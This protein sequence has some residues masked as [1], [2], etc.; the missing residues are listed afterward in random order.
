MW[1]ELFIAVASMFLD[2][3]DYGKPARF[4]LEAYL[5]ERDARNAEAAYDDDMWKYG[6]RG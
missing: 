5:N 6:W 4:E 2:G 1:A 3:S